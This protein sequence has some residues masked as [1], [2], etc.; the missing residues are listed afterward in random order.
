MKQVKLAFI[1]TALLLSTTAQASYVFS[2]DLMGEIV[3]EPKNIRAYYND[4]KGLEVERSTSQFLFKVTEAVPSGRA[5]SD[6]KAYIGEKIDVEL[7]NTSFHRIK[8]NAKLRINAFVKD[9][10]SMPRWKKFNLLE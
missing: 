5:D 7:E 10:Q 8:Q 4:E 2:C 9:G 1:T 6:C 3:S